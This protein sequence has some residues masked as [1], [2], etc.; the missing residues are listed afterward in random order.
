LAADARIDSES[1][2]ANEEDRICEKLQA[3]ETD[4]ACCRVLNAQHCRGFR[5]RHQWG[6]HAIFTI[7]EEIVH[8]EAE[9][10]S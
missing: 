8:G 7:R 4:T 2:S 5:F 10:N 1:I 3:Q 6:I 9:R